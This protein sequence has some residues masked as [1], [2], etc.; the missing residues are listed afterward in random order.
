MGSQEIR[1]KFFDFFIRHGHTKVPSSSLIPAHDPTLLFANA[2]MNQFKDVFLGKEKRRYTRAVSIQKCM[3]AGGKHN[4]LENVGFTARHLTFFEMMGNFSFGDYF[5]K[6]AIRFAW[7]FLTQELSLPQEKLFASVYK[8]DNEAY[9]IWHRD[10]GLPHERIS[11]LGETD[12]F[13]QMGDTGP[14][15]PCSEIYVDRG[16]GYGCA[17][18]SCGPGCVCDRFLEIWNLVFMQYDRQPDGTDKP[19]E[20]TGV[21]TGMGLERLCAVMQEKGSVYETD[22]FTGLIH[23]LEIVTGRIYDQASP[24]IKAAFRVLADHIRASCFAIA[25]GCVPSN[26]GRGY[27]VRKIIRRAALFAQKLSDKNIFPELAPT[28]MDQMGSL[29][30]ELVA[31]KDLI[32]K[33]ITSEIE[34][35]AHNLLQSQAILNTYLAEGQVERRITGNQAFKLYDTYGFPL[36]LTQVIAREHR[37]TVDVKG[38]EEEMERQRTQSGKKGHPTTHQ[39]DLVKSISTEFT[40][41]TELETRSMVTALLIDATPTERVTQG[42]RC[43][44][45][46]Q[47]SPFYVEG[48]GQVSDQGLIITS[49][50]ET[51][52]LSLKRIGQAIA[53]EIIAPEDL[54]ISDQVTLVVDA[55]KRL[56]TMKNHT[57]THLLQAALLAVLGKQVK[58]AGS[59]VAPDYLRFDFTYP[60]NLTAEQV[61]Q[62]ED[63]VNRKIWEN[64]TLRITFTTYK[65]ALDRG[66]I[67]FF[68]E[69]YNPEHVRVVEI[70]GSSAEL[71]GGTHVRATGDIGCFKITDVSALSVGVRRIV[72][73]TG[74]GALSLFQ[75]NF[76]LV[77]ALSQEFK[78]KPTE[79]L[80]AVKKQRDQLKS[81]L[82]EIKTLKKQFIQKQIPEWLTHVHQIG[83]LPFL[84]LSLQD[85]APDELRD[86]A[87]RLM[88]A[89]PGFYFIVSSVSDRVYF[90]AGISP[91][92]GKFIDLKE[93]TKWLKD[94]GLQGGGSAV[95]VQGSGAHLDPELREK[96]MTRVAENT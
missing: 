8:H 90:F 14:C 27:V 94:Y 83:S 13:W 33:L 77:K 16:L 62:V 10:I 64:I 22:L 4:D 11:R 65:D 96:I 85:T 23:S 50:G 44:V 37:F 2:G 69:K 72:A 40:G 56:D 74:P 82:T 86:I 42:Q 7:D 91:E 87:A 49:H 47:R 1:Q 32:V 79:A 81:A 26:E 36:E 92:Y 54:H 52:V 68:G 19:L 12:N 15:G 76:A 48:G 6:D 93:F 46:T 45:I 9:D 59:L 58:Q 35:F 80:D 43:W 57:A 30:P 18:P 41:Y 55:E 71:C 25:D 61:K 53:A 73:V 60:E 17:T 21:D 84:Y 67:A 51:S 89:K 24:E 3:R 28:L 39:P 78:V 34:K 70:P 88:Q 63:L 5:K 95:S 38:F 31:S 66:V 29:Y 75:E 20:Q